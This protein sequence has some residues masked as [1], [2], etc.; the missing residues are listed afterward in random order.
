MKAL[1][2]L[3][4][5]EEKREALV[6]PASQC[7][8]PEAG[9]ML[10]P[11]AALAHK[12]RLKAIQ[13]LIGFLQAP[14]GMRAYR[15]RNSI[16]TTT[17]KLVEYLARQNHVSTRTVWS[18]YQDWKHDGKLARARAD[19][20][21]SRTFGR[22]PE[23]IPDEITEQALE[24]LLAEM[25]PAGRYVA[26]LYLRDHYSMRECHLQLEREHAALGI[27][28]APS[29]SAVL[30]FLEACPP[31]L[32]HAAEGR[33]KRF[34]AAH[35]PFVWRDYETAE[36]NEWWVLD[37]AQDDFF[38]YNDFIPELGR[39]AFPD[40]APNAW[41]RMWLTA[42][43]DVRSRKVV[44]YAFCAD[45]HSGSILSAVRMAVVRTGSACKRGLIDRGNDFLSV[46]KGEK[47]KATPRLS[48]EEYGAFNRL[49]RAFHGE[50]SKI[51]KAIG[52][53]AQSKPIERLFRFKRDRFDSKVYS[54][55]GRSP[56]HRP[57]SAQQLLDAHAAWL[58]NGAQGEA[59]L[60]RASVAMLAT[61]AWIERDY[62]LEHRHTGHGMRGQTPEQVFRTGWSVEQERKARARLDPRALEEF[63]W[64]REARFIRNGQVQLFS[65]HYHAADAESLARLR[66][67]DGSESKVLVACDPYDATYAVAYD[68]QTGERLGALVPA[69]RFA[70]G[71]PQ[72]NIKAHLSARDNGW[73]ACQKILRALP[74]RTAPK[75]LFGFLGAEFQPPALPEGV[76]APSPKVLRRRHAQA[77][78]QQFSSPFVDDAA[79]KFRQAMQEPEEEAV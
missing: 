26:G 1:A 34:D 48:V 51:V 4:E 50:N 68:P 62:N 66:V 49:L 25:T 8:A 74:Q 59:P 58:K 20:G 6:D 73:R 14:L 2:T 27:E 11:R 78:E 75:N 43:M 28:R 18:W 22:W 53:N 21:A 31:M 39:F 10:S 47:P 32:K 33:R 15:T 37:H 76:V 72:E 71:E 52:E 19:Y 36:V 23:S 29:Y 45:P 70:W 60:P 65:A 61:A 3:A 57:D 54:R 44:G 24:A 42:C 5:R 79:A 13:P 16:I 46:A 77:E 63:L 41:L 40:H 12:E 7:D 17:R 35:R 38:V 69:R 67:W 55:C 9:E 30:R 64:K 56:E